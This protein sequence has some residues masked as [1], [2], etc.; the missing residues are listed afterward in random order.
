MNA[1]NNYFHSTFLQRNQLALLLFAAPTFETTRTREP[2][3]AVYPYLTK[4]PNSKPAQGTVVKHL[5]LKLYFHCPVSSLV[6]L[7]GIALCVA[8]QRCSSRSARLTPVAAPLLTWLC[9]CGCGHARTLKD[10]HQLLQPSV[11]LIWVFPKIIL[12]ISSFFFPSCPSPVT[13]S[14]GCAVLYVYA[15]TRS[16]FLARPNPDPQPYANTDI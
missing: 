4:L 1:P 7:F 5:F 3:R 16:F 14:P 15:G 9:V 10:F 8:G 13:A 2:E 6:Y 12:K 11:S